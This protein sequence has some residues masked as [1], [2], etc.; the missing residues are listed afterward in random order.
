MT[1]ST[2]IYQYKINKITIILTMVCTNTGIKQNWQCTIITI[3][4]N[5]KTRLIMTYIYLCKK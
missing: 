5:I 4:N 3:L 2:K 1:L